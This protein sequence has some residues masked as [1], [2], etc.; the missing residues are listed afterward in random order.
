MKIHTQYTR[1]FP[2]HLLHSYHLIRNGGCGRSHAARWQGELSIEERND[3][4]CHAVPLVES[5]GFGK[6]TAEHFQNYERRCKKERIFFLVSLESI[7]VSTKCNIYMHVYIYSY[8]LY[9]HVD[10]YILQNNTV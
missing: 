5:Q 1:L 7:H 4:L 2:C 8:I 3:P 9:M 6:C 10:T